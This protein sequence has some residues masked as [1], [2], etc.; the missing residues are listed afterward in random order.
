[1][2]VINNNQAINFR[3]RIVSEPVFENGF[4][5]TECEIIDTNSD[6]VLASGRAFCHPEDQFNK[7]IG[8]KKALER[9]LKGFSKEF[10]EEAW[11]AYMKR[12]PK[13]YNL[14]KFKTKEA[15]NDTSVC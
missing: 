1:M 6:Q 9:A 4:R 12:D 11:L 13:R 10:R 15:I 5:C 14:K 3:H 8:R 7:E 2:V